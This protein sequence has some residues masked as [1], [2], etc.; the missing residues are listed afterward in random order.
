MHGVEKFNN[1]IIPDEM[2]ENKIILI[3]GQKVML[4]KDLADLYNVDTSMLKRAVRRNL[5]RFPDDFMFEL[6]KEEQVSLRCHFGTLKRGRHAKYL[7]YAFSEQGI[8]MLSSVL[9]SKRAI[10]VNIQIIRT[11]TKLRKLLISHED[12]KRKIISMETKYD[13]QFK[14]VFDAIRQLLAPPEKPKRRIGFHADN[15]N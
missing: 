9:N 8:A 12:L 2:I 11:F 14:I 4:D 7:P 5:L 13:H 10:L 3:R 15:N 6:T 1:I